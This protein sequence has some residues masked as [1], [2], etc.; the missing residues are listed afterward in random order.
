[1]PS[2]FFGGFFGGSM[3]AIDMSPFLSQIAF[4][5]VTVAVI[6]IAAALVVVYVAKSAAG[7]VLT[8]IYNGFQHNNNLRERE[9]KFESRLRRER[10]NSDY[11]QWKSRRKF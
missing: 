9:R 8:Q 6:S 11:R 10:D 7:Q 1:M 2:P 5:T 3:A 4:G